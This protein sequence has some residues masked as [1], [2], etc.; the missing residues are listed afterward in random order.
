MLWD[1]QKK[2]FLPSLSRLPPGGTNHYFLEP[3]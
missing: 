2:R 3:I 1:E